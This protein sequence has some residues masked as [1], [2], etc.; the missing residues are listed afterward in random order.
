M[1]FADVYAKLKTC[2]QTVWRNDQGKLKV[3][4]NHIVKAM[5]RFRK[6]LQIQNSMGF[7]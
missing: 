3:E 5:V 4:L 2:D 6:N 1:T 7:E